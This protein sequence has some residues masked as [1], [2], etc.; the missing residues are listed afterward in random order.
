M[1]DLKRAVG[2]VFQ[3]IGD[4]FESARSGSKKIA[5]ALGYGSVVHQLNPK[6]APP[7]TVPM[8]DI[9]QLRLAQ[10]KRLASQ[11]QMGRAST[12]LSSPD[13]EQLGP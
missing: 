5:R 4:V 3:G 11:A 13:S 9:D 2:D 12:I 10:K 6:I 1:G 8:P 7:P